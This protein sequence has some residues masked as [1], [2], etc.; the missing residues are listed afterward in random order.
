MVP[1]D[2]LPRR[3]TGSPLLCSALLLGLPLLLSF[4]VL[5]TSAAALDL[6]S[7]AQNKYGFKT[8][9]KYMKGDK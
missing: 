1:P 8:F 4:P 3:G 2:L 6:P 9:I 7:P 5:V